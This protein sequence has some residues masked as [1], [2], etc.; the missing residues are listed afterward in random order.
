ML[1]DLVAKFGRMPDSSRLRLGFSC[2]APLAAALLGCASAAPRL[3]PGEPPTPGSVSR[4]E[5][6]GDAADPHEAALLRQLQEPWGGRRDKDNQ[7]VV[8]VPDRRIDQRVRFWALDHF[9]GFRY[10][11]DYHVVNVVF[12]HDLPEG[13][14]NDSLTCLRKIEKWGRPQLKAFEV[15][16]GEFQTVEQE[17]RDHEI[18]VK[19]VDGHVDFGFK[20]RHFSAA[21]AAYPAYPNACIVFGMAVPWDDHE[22]LAKKVRDRWVAEAVPLLRPL[23]ET[24]PYRKE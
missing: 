3:P 6:G 5:P 9:V 24:R 11:A 10:G 15:K 13:T 18:L 16:L 23:T 4:E 12:I 7:L 19:T 8:P 14:R 2:L 21:Y 22:Q 20:R 1:P 17:W